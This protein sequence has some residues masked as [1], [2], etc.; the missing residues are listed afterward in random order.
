VPDAIADGN[1]FGHAEGH[2]HRQ[3]HGY[4]DGQ[5]HRHPE[6]DSLGIP[7]GDL[8]RQT[9]CLADRNSRSL[10]RTHPNRHL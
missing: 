7:E 1:T 3:G 9:D 5:G 6:A 10:G 4:R 2:C 8:S